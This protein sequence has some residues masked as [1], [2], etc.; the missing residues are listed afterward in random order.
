MARDERFDDVSLSGESSWF[1]RRLEP[2]EVRALPAPLQPA[3]FT[4]GPAVINDDLRALAFALDDEVSPPADAPADAADLPRAAQIVLT[5]PHRLAGTL[6]WGRRLASI[7]PVTDKPRIPVKFR[8]RVTGK[9]FVVWL[10]QAGRY[11]YGLGDWYRHNDIPAGAHIEVSRGPDDSTFLVDYRRHRPR[12]E[13]VRVATQRDSRL[14]LETAQRAVGC[15]F[16]EQMSVFCDDPGAFAALRGAAP[17]DVAQAVRE[18][19]P[20]V[21]KLSPQ[22][23]VHASTLYAVVNVITRAAPEDVFAALTASGMYQSV[24]DAYWHLSEARN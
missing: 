18:A 19:F 2:P 6:G 17:R 16:D 23:N 1:L 7:L 24:G 11:I 21:A 3:V 22:G 13:W 15:D 5:F 4:G 14:R 12:R 20:E 9:E 10:V 8:D